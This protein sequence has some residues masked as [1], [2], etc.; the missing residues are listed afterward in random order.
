M[1]NKLKIAVEQ[2][3]HISPIKNEK[4]FFYFRICRTIEVLTGFCKSTFEFSTNQLIMT[5]NCH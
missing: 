1:R 3:Y 2:N 5:N 4:L